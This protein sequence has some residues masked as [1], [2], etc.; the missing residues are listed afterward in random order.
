MECCKKECATAF[1]PS[2]G[3]PI[4]NDPLHGLLLHIKAGV[5]SRTTAAANHKK[6]DRHQYKGESEENY[7]ERRR[8][9][10]KQSENKLKAAAKWESWRD[11]LIELMENTPGP[12]D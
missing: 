11:A 8:Y 3:K 12:A 1:C 6:H 9:C 5:V 10:R 7:E 4:D 2:C